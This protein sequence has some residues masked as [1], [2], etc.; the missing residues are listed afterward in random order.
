MMNIL[1]K[2]L[3][4]ILLV[5][6]AKVSATPTDLFWTNCTTE[7]VDTGYLNIQLIDF[8]TVTHPHQKIPD[9]PTDVGLTLGVFTWKFLS[10]E[11]GIDYLAATNSPVFF[12]T[13]VGF[14]K[15]KLYKGAPG[16]NVGIFNVGT[17]GNT[18]YNV[19]DMMV[20]KSLTKNLA[21]FFGGFRGSRKLGKNPAGIWGG[22]EYKFCPDKDAAGTEYYHCY[23]DADYASGKNFL[24][25]GGVSFVYFFV[26]HINI[27][28]G[29]I[30]F[31]D[32]HLLG[33]CKWEV[34]IVIG[35]PVY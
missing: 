2:L 29:P 7:I 4:S 34:Q 6:V 9:F 21:V 26:P 33:Q 32:A 13:K 23:I 25:G 5:S 31:N 24:G 12:N 11:A 14:D 15:D 16:F 3:A 18:N 27:Q 10:C 30:W 35:I 8:F 20:S 1:K 17:S 28:A 22:I 19:I